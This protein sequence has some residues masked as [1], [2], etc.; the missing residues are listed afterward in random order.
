MLAGCEQ[1]CRRSGDAQAPAAEM[2]RLGGAAN[3]VVRGRQALC[4]AIC[5]AG[6][7][8]RAG[9]G[10]RARVKSFSIARLWHPIRW[11]RLVCCA[12][13]KEESCGEV[14]LYSHNNSFSRC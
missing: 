10:E 8:A 5:V 13:A 11:S 1:S 14:K 6:R 9:S 12:R 7:T 2:S 4:L 3:I